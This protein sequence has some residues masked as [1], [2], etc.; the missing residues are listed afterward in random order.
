MKLSIVSKLVEWRIADMKNSGSKVLLCNC[1]FVSWFF[2]T[3]FFFFIFLCKTDKSHYSIKKC[4]FFKFFCGIRGFL[5]LTWGLEKKR[6][7]VVVHHTPTGGSSVVVAVSVP[8]PYGLRPYGVERPPL[9]W[10]CSNIQ[11]CFTSS[12]VRIANKQGCDYR[13]DKR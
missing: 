9:S 2:F 10:L 11:Y 8:L 1:C 3:F 4:I 12:P 13:F 6:R 5:I 7:K